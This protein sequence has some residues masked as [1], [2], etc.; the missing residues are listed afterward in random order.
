MNKSKY[1]SVFKDLPALETHRLILR[2]LGIGDA[3]E[4]Y[5]YASDDE[6]VKYVT[7]WAHSTIE[8][9]IRYIKFVLEQY[10]TGECA[11]WGIVLKQNQKLIGSCGFVRLDEKNCVGEVGYVL[12]RKY[13]GQGIMPEAVSALFKFGFEVLCLN[14]IEACHMLGNDRSGRVMEKCSMI[15]EGT[16]RDKMFVKG[17]LKSVKLYS[18]LR[19]EWEKRI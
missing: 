6:T 14:R 4:I 1:R 5:E 12:S 10:D 19:S 13:W 17:E 9:S 2:K 15:Y 16:L 7:W 8:D 3:Q 11:D 18:I